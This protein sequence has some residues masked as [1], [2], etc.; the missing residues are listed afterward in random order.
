MVFAGRIGKPVREVSASTR[1]GFCVPAQGNTL[2]MKKF[3]QLYANALV[4]ALVGLPRL[5][6]GT[7]L[8]VLPIAIIGYA[9]SFVIPFPFA[10]IAG[11]LAGVYVF[12]ETPYGSFIKRVFPF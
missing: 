4:A 10:G 5:I 12:E 9:V 1:G 11:M 8:L 2:G 6:A 3:L 7:V